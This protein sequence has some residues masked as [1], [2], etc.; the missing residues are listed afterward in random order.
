MISSIPHGEALLCLQNISVLPQ[1]LDQIFFF[2][3]VF[4]HEYIFYSSSPLD[5]DVISNALM[6]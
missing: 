5:S 4:F 2:N 6:K 1:P 3:L